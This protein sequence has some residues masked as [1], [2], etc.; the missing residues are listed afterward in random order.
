MKSG[1]RNL[2]IVAAAIVV[3]GGA[4]AVLALTGG[5]KGAS[6]SAA[7]SSIN[8][9][10]KKSDD[11]VSMSVKNKK[12][13]Y[14][15][16]PE[17]VPAN[18]AAANFTASGSA[19]SASSGSATTTTYTVEGLDGAPVDSSLTQQVFQ[20]GYSLVGS[21][22]LGETGKPEEFGLKDPQATVEVHYKD[23]KSITYL[24]GNAS[25]TDSTAYYMCTQGSSRVYVVSVDPGIFESKTYF[26]K[27][28]ILSISSDGSGTASSD[29]SGANDFTAI[30]LTGK[31]YAKPIVLYQEGSALAMTS[32]YKASLDA[33]NLTALEGALT[34]VTAASV[35][36]VNPD[37]AAL[38]KYGLDNPAAA[39]SFLVNNGAYKLLAG[40]K[41]GD[42]YYVMLDKGKI[43]Y[44][45]AASSIDAWVNTT[46]FALRSKNLLIPAVSTVKT[47]TFS[48]GGASSSVTVARTKDEKQSTQDN[49]VYT[50]TATA[51]GG[52][53]LDYD[54]V[55]QPFYA[56]LIAP[57]ILE[58]SAA[59]PS[60]SPV[61]ALEYQYFDKSG[62]DTVQ[63]Y[64]AGDRRYLAAVNGET[65]GIVTSSDIDTLY[66]EWQQMLSGKT[67][68]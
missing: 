15:I 38:K 8:L 24:I 3:L 45:V 7:S 19:S 60:G 1:T 10:S 34:T 16:V 66:A 57:E 52:T 2:V 13:S 48:K 28:D 42:N 41:T 53:K 39:V 44:Q 25:A 29:S 67:G 5:G 47:V 61:Y 14:Q 32:P 35:E 58:E 30:T 31:N 49:T 6:S 65:A 63:F 17:I 21:Q 33:T 23:G 12:G 40:S 43:V 54:K 55:Y 59:K 27:K 37:A 36:A 22:D 20:N 26:V 18:S 11:V 50:Y 46:A 62:K 9:I 51:A 4:A 68:S 56:K 64:A